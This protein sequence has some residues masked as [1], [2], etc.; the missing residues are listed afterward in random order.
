MCFV[1]PHRSCSGSKSRPGLGSVLGKGVPSSGLTHLHPLSF[2]LCHEHE[3]SEHQQSA[4]T[5]TWGSGC[6][7]RLWDWFPFSP[8][9]FCPWL[10]PPHSG[11][12]HSIHPLPLFVTTY[13]SNIVIPPEVTSLTH[14]LFIQRPDYWLSIGILLLATGEWLFTQPLCVLYVTIVG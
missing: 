14:S 5:N 4:S 13:F 6:P 7:T 2:V 11:C 3:G 10:W 8:P 12:E 9:F 1:P